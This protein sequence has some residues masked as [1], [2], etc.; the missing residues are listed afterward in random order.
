MFGLLPSFN[1]N[2]YV[3]YSGRDIYYPTSLMKV[4]ELVHYLGI[5]GIKYSNIGDGNKIFID[6]SALGQY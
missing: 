3:Y 4:N 1:V 5:L 6:L 2:Y